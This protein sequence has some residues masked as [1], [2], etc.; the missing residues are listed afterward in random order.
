MHFTNWRK[1]GKQVLWRQIHIKLPF[2][3]VKMTRWW[4]SLTFHPERR[5][6]SGIPTPWFAF[7]KHLELGANCQPRSLW[8][9]T[10]KVK[11]R[12]WGSSWCLLSYMLDCFKNPLVFMQLINSSNKPLFVHLPTLPFGQQAAGLK[13]HPGLVSSFRE[14]PGPLPFLSQHSGQQSGIRRALFP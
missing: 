11:W 8:T 2:L 5:C 3:W 4:A 7:T 6:I 1:I 9:I 10:P 13:P 12:T 14:S